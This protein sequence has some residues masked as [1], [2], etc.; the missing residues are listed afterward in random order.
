M[1]YVFVPKICTAH[2][3]PIERTIPYWM[4]FDLLFQ[5][6]LFSSSSA[7]LLTH[8]HNFR[9][10][11]KKTSGNRCSA[12]EKWWTFLYFVPLFLFLWSIVCMYSLN[13]TYI[14][15]TRF[16]LI[17]VGLYRHFELKSRVYCVLLASKA[18]SIGHINFHSW[19]KIYAFNLVVVVVVDFFSFGRAIV[20]DQARA[21]AI[22]SPFVLLTIVFVFF[23]NSS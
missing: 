2:L 7:F 6:V 13:Y 9:T 3:S 5:L 22:R 4:H 12:A 19:P 11:K 23:F 1:Y 10:A 14:S 8:L 15:N 18:K 20:L 21:L 17:F 16:M